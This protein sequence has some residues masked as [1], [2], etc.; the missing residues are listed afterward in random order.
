MKKIAIVLGMTILLSGCQITAP[1]T[2]PITEFLSDVFS[3]WKDSNEYDKTVKVIEDM[4]N[5]VVL[6]RTKQLWGEVVYQKI[7]DVCDDRGGKVGQMPN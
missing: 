2:D 6:D 1:I 7:K 5:P 3:R 4:C